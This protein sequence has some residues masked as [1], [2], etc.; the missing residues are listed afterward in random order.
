MAA[1]APGGGPAGRQGNQ[2][3]FNKITT[4][5]ASQS[6]NKGHGAVSC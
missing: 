1:G 6:C 3:Q 4:I 2:P 5:G